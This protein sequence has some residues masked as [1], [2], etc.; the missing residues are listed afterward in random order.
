MKKSI[1]AKTIAPMTP[2]WVVGTYDPEG[3]PNAMTAAWGGI[4]CSKP[5]CIYVSLREATYT[6]HSI[7]KRGAFTVSVPSESH[8]READYFGIASGK[9]ADKFKEAG[10]TPV[11]SDVVDAP[12]VGEFPVILE[13]R[14][15]ET[16]KIGLH[17]EFI[18]EILDVKAD[19]DVLTKTNLPDM[20]KVKPLV[21]NTSGLTYHGIGKS[22]GRA[23]SIGKK[24]MDARAGK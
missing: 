10:L 4:C 20:R 2:V 13:C 6:Y 17:T 24:P 23:F 12:Y 18:G 14:L 8:V 11:R 5:P 3:R 19:A 9:K 1:G 7:M 15:I 22:V 21:W 16:V